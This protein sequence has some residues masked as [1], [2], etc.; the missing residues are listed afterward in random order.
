MEHDVSQSWIVIY[1]QVVNEYDVHIQIREHVDIIINGE[2]IIDFCHVQVV[3]VTVFH[4]E[5]HT[6][7]LE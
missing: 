4:D 5:K 3:V 1:E 7:Q 6:I 2:I